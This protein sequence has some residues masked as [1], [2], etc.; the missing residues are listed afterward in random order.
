MDKEF[1]SNLIEFLKAIHIPE[2]R[3][4]KL[5]SNVCFENV[6]VRLV[7]TKPKVL[8]SRDFGRY[9]Q[10]RLRSITKD[11]IDYYNKVTDHPLRD[12]YPVV[13]QCNG[14]GYLKRP[15]IKE[16]ISSC[17]GGKEVKEDVNDLFQIV[18]PSKDYVL[19]SIRPDVPVNMQN[20]DS[21]FK[22]GHLKTTCF[23]KYIPTEGRDRSLPR[24][25][26]CSI[27]VNNIVVVFIKPPNQPSKL[28]WV[29]AG[30][31][32]ISFSA[33]GCFESKQK[34]FRMNNYEIGVVLLPKNFVDYYNGD[35]K[36]KDWN[37]S[38]VEDDYLQNVDLGFQIP[39]EPFQDGE[40]EFYLDIDIEGISYVCSRH[41]TMMLELYLLRK[42]FY[43]D[44][45]LS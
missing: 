21:T 15:F 30:S 25:H 2:H 13:C 9:G 29:Y 12:V 28:C 39:F 4:F 7:T 20:N 34:R 6:R 3:I 11:L 45:D 40:R 22:K 16:I 19:N 14:L 32:S 44:L 35:L 8:S 10:L 43:F 27:V 24:S 41:A 18:Y 1:R 5:I 26:Y 36:A 31:H 17:N 38:I 42:P 23:R 37:Q 33:W